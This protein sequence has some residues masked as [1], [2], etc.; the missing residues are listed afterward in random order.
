MRWRRSDD[1]LCVRGHTRCTVGTVVA[2]VAVDVSFGVAGAGLGAEVVVE[3]T[4]DR[5]VLRPRRLV[6][7]VVRDLSSSIVR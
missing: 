6:I 1:G 5:G 3:E 4:E 2:A 7:V